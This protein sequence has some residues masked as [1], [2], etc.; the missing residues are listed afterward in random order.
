[1]LLTMI[2]Y[3]S[4]F[5]KGSAIDIRWNSRTGEVQYQEG[6]KRSH[7]DSS[8]SKSQ[9]RQNQE[10]YQNQS[11]QEISQ[12]LKIKKSNLIKSKIPS[13]Q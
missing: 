7:F 1:M 2:N 6:R 5:K 13:N 9:N 10:I 8:P 3:K 4:Y 12:I 11:N